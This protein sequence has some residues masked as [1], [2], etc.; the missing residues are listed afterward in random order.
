[1]IQFVAQKAFPHW[2]T[3][4]ITERDVRRIARKRGAQI[5]EGKVG[6]LGL[7]IIY[8]GVPFIVIDPDLNGPMRLWVLLH[9][10]AHHLLHVPGLQLFDHRFETKADSEANLLAA[11][12]MIPR[13]WIETK[14][15]ADLLEED[16]PR[17][18]LWVR[19][20]IF[21]QHGF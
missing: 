18:L 3:L 16:Y 15:F 5:V 7:Y 19:K 1:M 12:A 10:L 21:E 11:V 6:V 13:S 4:P 9:E 2:N 8:G 17:D 14:S 20:E